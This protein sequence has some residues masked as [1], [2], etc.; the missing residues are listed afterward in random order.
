MIARRDGYPI[1]WPEQ[2]HFESP[3]G[4]QDGLQAR[5]ADCIDFSNLGKS[6]FGRKKELAPATEAPDR[7]GDQE[8]RPGQS[9]PFIVNNMMNNVP[10]MVDEPMATLLWR[11]RRESPKYL[12]TP[13]IV[14]IA[15]YN[16]QDVV[17][18]AHRTVRMM[19]AATRAGV[20]VATPIIVRQ[21][22]EFGPDALG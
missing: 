21:P 22:I 14:P 13:S 15:H 9:K 6:I 8:V 16:G 10:R 20:A 12:A 11:K 2:I 1:I 17:P 19:K 7:Q 18:K 5:L 3:T 4:K